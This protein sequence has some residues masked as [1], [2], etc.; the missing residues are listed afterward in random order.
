MSFS[1]GLAKG[2]PVEVWGGVCLGVGEGEGTGLFRA[3]DEGQKEADRRT[4]CR[5]AV[6]SPGAG[7]HPGVISH[8]SSTGQR[9][10][11]SQWSHGPPLAEPQW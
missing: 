3:G 9:D 8:P 10:L 11:Q 6:S 7:E 1:K 2:G 4:A 5:G